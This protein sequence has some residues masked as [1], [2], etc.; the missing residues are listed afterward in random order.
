MWHVNASCMLLISA[1]DGMANPWR[2]V[3]SHQRMFKAHSVIRVW[4]WRSI[5]TLSRS[6]ST[7]RVDSRLSP[8]HR[9]WM[10][11]LKS[12]VTIKITI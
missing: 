12:H 1:Y 5:C 11:A 2:I 3:M 9:P 6:I 8:L 7:L 4:Y 10:L